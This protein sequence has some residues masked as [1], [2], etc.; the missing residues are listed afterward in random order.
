VRRIGDATIHGYLDRRTQGE[1]LARARVIVGRS[2]YT[3]LMECAAFGKRALFVPT[4]GQSEQEY[5]AKLHCQRGRVFSTVQSALD[6]A[7]DLQRADAAR[8][9]P[10]LRVDTA[11][12]RFL[13]LLP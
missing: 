4:P 12:P 7:R 3:T 5:L 1:M 2:G 11:V 6:I 13:A 8:G 10:R 9:L